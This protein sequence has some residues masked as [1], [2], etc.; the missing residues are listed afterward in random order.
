MASKIK[1]FI[2]QSISVFLGFTFFG[3]GMAKLYF[4]HHYF[5]WIGPTWLIEK[6]EEYQL[7]LYGQFIA[8]SQIFIGYFLFTT[9][10][11]LL[12]GIMMIP[13]IANTLMVTVSLHWKGTPYV[14]AFLLG[15]NILLLW[16]YRDFFKPMLNETFHG[17][18]KRS[19]R[20]RSNLGHLI[21]LCGLALQFLSIA[22]SYHSIY[23]AMGTS[24]L[25]L[26]L[27]LFSFRIDKSQAKKE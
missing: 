17:N 11:K 8:I 27:S 19:E 24:F 3:A 21:W 15:L 1:N 4:E 13:L 7:G 18:F 26:L 16:H 6:L 12:G 14:L 5:G 2:L 20:T 10:Y 23:L 25:G 22:L 9:R